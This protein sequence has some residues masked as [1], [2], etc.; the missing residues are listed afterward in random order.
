[1]PTD[2][3]PAPVPLGARQRELELY[4]SGDLLGNAGGCGGV[5]FRVSGSYVS[6]LKFLLGFRLS[7]AVASARAGYYHGFRGARTPGPFFFFVLCYS[8]T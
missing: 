4:S 1:M 7:G 3:R 8:F 6:V 5:F 2:V